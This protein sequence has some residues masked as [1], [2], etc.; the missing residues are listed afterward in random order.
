[1]VAPICG[2]NTCPR[3][4]YARVL[5]PLGRARSLSPATRSSLRPVSILWIYRWPY[6]VSGRIGKCLIRDW[7]EVEFRLWRSSHRGHWSGELPAHGTSAHWTTRL[8]TPL[9]AVQRGHHKDQEDVS[10]ADRWRALDA[11][12]LHCE[13]KIEYLILYPY[14][15]SYIY[16]SCLLVSPSAD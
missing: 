4:A 9:G 8:R 10:H 13:F 5:A 12:A 1:M 11:N 7:V 15:I 14:I 16:S 2:V 6:R 3:N